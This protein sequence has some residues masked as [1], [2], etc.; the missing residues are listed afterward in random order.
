MTSLSDTLTVGLV[1]VLLFGS[2]ALY[3]YTRLQQAEQKISLLESILLDL[4]MSAEIKTY[5]ELPASEEIKVHASDVSSSS[6]GGN[7]ATYKPFDE[8]E[9]E[10]TAVEVTEY[11]PLDEI[12]GTESKHSSRSSS[13]PPSHTDDADYAPG[14][15]ISGYKDVVASALTEVAS[16]SPSSP[17]VSYEG[18]TIKELQALAKSRGISSANSMKKASLIEALKTSDK[19]TSS[20]EPGSASGTAPFLETSSLLVGVDA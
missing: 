14:A 12:V 9:T 11:T 7:V 2:I 17:S 20:I 3:L 5:T 6:S 10:S 16:S 4:K 1:L 8:E 15:V 18:M 19:A 13:P